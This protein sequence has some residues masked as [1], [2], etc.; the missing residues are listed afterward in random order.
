M[1]IPCGS[2][3]DRSTRPARAKMRLATY[4]NS[5]PRPEDVHCDGPSS[6][7]APLLVRRVERWPTTE[8]SAGRCVD[9]EGRKPTRARFSEVPAERPG[10]YRSIRIW[11]ANRDMPKWALRHDWQIFGQVVDSSKFT[12]SD[13]GRPTKRWDPQGEIMLLCCRTTLRSLLGRLGGRRTRRM[14]WMALRRIG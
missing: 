1:Y 2:S 4:K 10:K 11:W 3:S 9:G 8:C 13:T 14:G 12:T 7:T 6:S 5:G